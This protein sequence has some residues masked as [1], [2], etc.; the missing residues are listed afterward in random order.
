M[1]VTG[2]AAG[3]G[4]MDLGEAVLAVMD[5]AEVGVTD[6]V[7]EVSAVMDS[8]AAVL[9]GEVLAPSGAGFSGRGFGSGFN[10]THGFAGRGFS[11]RGDRGRFGDRG[12]R[13]RDRGF[14]DFEGDSFDFGFYGFG[15]PDYYQYDYPYYYSYPYYN[16]NAYL[17]VDNSGDYR[18]SATSDVTS[19][20]QSELSKRGYYQGPI[21]GVLGAGSRRAIRSF[22]TDQRLPITGSID[23]KLLS[24]LRVG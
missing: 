10:G 22:Q 6:S 14:G 20:V 19:V 13:G 1:G 2:A 12:F 17:G 18:R 4:V 5:S 7:G 15:Y 8:A 16:Y 3:V 24:A 23:R 9:V 11:G 21:D